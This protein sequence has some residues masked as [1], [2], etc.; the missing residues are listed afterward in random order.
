MSL[1]ETLKLSFDMTKVLTDMEVHGIKINVDTLHQLRDEYQ[2]EMIILNKKLDTMVKEAMGDTPINLDSGEDRS[3]VMYSCKVK[4]KNIWKNA[5]NLG[6]EVRRGGAKRPK[7]RPNLSK[8]D[9]NRMV[10]DMTDV[11]YKTKVQ[12]CDNCYG[13][14][15]IKKYTVKGDLYKIAPK[16]PKFGLLH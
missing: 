7:K 14:G 11:V 5:F 2:T 13:K 1:T 6:T 3:V 16:C 8:R 15:T 12:Q 10:A 9:F 4:D